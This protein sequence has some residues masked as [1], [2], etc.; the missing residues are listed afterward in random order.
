MRKL[1]ALAILVLLAVAG[2]LFSA[3]VA[4]RRQ[5]K[6]DAQ[7]EE[8]VVPVRVMEAALG[9]VESSFTVDGT[10]QAVNEVG[11][12]SK[13]PGKIVR[14]RYDEG[15]WV[16]RGA[17]VA[18]LDRTELVAQVAMAEA[19]LKAAR[20]RA[21]QARHGHRL[22]VASTSVGVEEAEAALRAARARLAQ[23]EATTTLTGEDVTTSVT[24]AEETV[25]MA[26][27]RLDA[28]RAGARPQ[29]RSIAREAVNQAKANL[30]TAAK[31]LDRARRLLEAQAISQQQFDAAKL[32]YDIA[33]AS[34]Q[35]AQ[36]QAD[37][38]EEGPRAEEIRAAE[39]QL[40]Q[41][42]A[43][44]AKA[45]AMQLQVDVRRRD[46]E[47]AREAVRQAEAALRMARTSSIR[48]TIS[49]GDIK[50][51]DAAVAQAAAN[52]QYA[53]ANVANTYIYAPASGYVVRRN[54]RPGE[55]A[56]PSFPILNLVDN[57]E[58]KVLCAL[59]EERRRLVSV[60]QEVTFTVDALP[61]KVFHGRVY[62][63]SAAASPESRAFQM[64]IRLPNP[65][66]LLKSG[67]FARVK[68]TV[69]RQSSVV[70]IPYDAVVTAGQEKVVFVAE[71]SVA[72]SR[73]VQLGLRE[74]DKVA[75]LR[76][77]APG[78]LVVVQGQNELKDGQKVS[79]ERV[80]GDAS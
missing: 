6:L 8:I 26:Q 74:A 49:A 39:A 20:V 80:R 46:I 61:G 13:V 25:R 54:I 16:E 12:Y 78:E 14:L 31:N 37:L 10:V 19:A 3:T 28:L 67:M 68:V 77:L 32:Q 5:A 76:G 56:S 34:Y 21:S 63:I 41:A 70:V 40:E 51:A 71:G 36:Q 17:L 48:D 52:L 9:T 58:V 66:Q 57:R 30:D 50:A 64:E 33:L 60:G 22:Q 38:T 2:F 7:Q 79:A 18:E 69:Q 59:S 27:A 53:R 55:M 4:G 11:V 15:D 47:A 23:A 73:P 35:Q 24:A 42:K 43:N 29:E 65:G 72:R 62:N 45:K 44:L 75:I 1:I